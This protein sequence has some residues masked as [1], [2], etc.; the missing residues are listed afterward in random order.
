MNVII[1]S[2]KRDDFLVM[3]IYDHAITYLIL[4]FMLGKTALRL[5]STLLIHSKVDKL[6]E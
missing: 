2:V 4:I 1:F 3:K 6:T 5:Q